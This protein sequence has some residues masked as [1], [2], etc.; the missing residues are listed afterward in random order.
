MPSWRNFRKFAYQCGLYEAQDVFR[1][2][3]DVDLICPTPRKG[4]NFTEGLQKRLMWHDVSRRLAHVNPGLHPVRLEGEYDLFV[5]V[6]QSWWDIFFINAI[7]GWQDHCKISVCLIDELWAASIPEYK[8]WLHVFKKFDHVFLGFQESVPAL[9][10]AIGRRCHW[11]PGAVDAI[12]FSPYPTPSARV[13]DVYSMGRRWEGIHRSMLE[14]ATRHGMFYI[15]DTFPGSTARPS[16]HQQHRDLIANIAKR[17]RFFVVGPAKLG[18][19]A[20]TRGQVEIGYRFFEGAAAGAVMIGQAPECS[21]FRKLF[22]WPDAVLHLETDGSNVAEVMSSFR[23]EPERFSKIGRRNARESLLQ[24][25]WAYRWRQILEI[26]GL[27]PA[28]A[29]EKRERKLKELAGLTDCED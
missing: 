16:D 10:Q 4:F 18:V 17:S 22:G 24:H 7:K 23:N 3:D 15:Y 14:A 21:S 29:L 27:K 5:A 1:T 11:L 12:R 26:A 19:D 28:P 20:D 8:Y 25:D 2:V 9:E 13:V 6:C